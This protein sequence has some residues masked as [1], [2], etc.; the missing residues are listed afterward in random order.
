[1]IDMCVKN[2]NTVMGVYRDRREDG[3]GGGCNVG[4]RRGSGGGGYGQSCRR[5]WGEGAGWGRER[6]KGGLS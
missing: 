4:V 1:M 6:V 2:G 3:D 5:G